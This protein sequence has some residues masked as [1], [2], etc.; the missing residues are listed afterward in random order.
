MEFFLFIKYAKKTLFYL[1][2]RE[3]FHKINKLL[4]IYETNGAE[5]QGSGTY[6]S[7]VPCEE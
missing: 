2:K 3:V 1:F 4:S 7:I 5:V 6:F